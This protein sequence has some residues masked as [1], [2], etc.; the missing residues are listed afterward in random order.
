MRAFRQTAGQVLPRLPAPP[1]LPPCPGGAVGPAQESQVARGTRTAAHRRPV[2]APFQCPTEPTE[3]H[4]SAQGSASGSNLKEGGR[5][6]VFRA[7]ISILRKRRRRQQRQ[8]L[9]PA[10]A[11]CPTAGANPQPAPRC[12]RSSALPGT[13][14]PAAEGRIRL[15]ALPG[16]ERLHACCAG[17]LV[18]REPPPCGPPCAPAGAAGAAATQAVPTPTTC[19]PSRSNPCASR[20]ARRQ[21]AAGARLLWGMHE[22]L[23]RAMMKPLCRNG[24][25]GGRVPM[26]LALLPGSSIASEAVGNSS[27]TARFSP[28]QPS[29]CYACRLPG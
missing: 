4:G 16:T 2:R 22:R 17:Q 26:R 27:L 15:P 25:V 9:P 5:G 7:T 1:P 3:P 24:S 29:P 8:G 13:S 28:T 12:A 20:C 21:A 14:E 11:Y 10:A 23:G 6:V 19:S 18:N